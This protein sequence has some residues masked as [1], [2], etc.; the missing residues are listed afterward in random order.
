M[1]Y[2]Q[3]VRHSCG[4]LMHRWTLTNVLGIDCNKMFAISCSNYLLQVTNIEAIL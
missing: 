3:S 2:I 4:D 1:G